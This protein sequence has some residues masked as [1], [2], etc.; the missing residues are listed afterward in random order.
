MFYLVTTVE[1]DLFGVRDYPGM[2]VTEVG[3]P[4]CL[5]GD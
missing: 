2:D 1:R 4:V 5:H 3:L